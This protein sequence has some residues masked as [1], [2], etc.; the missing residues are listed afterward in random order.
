MREAVI[1]GLGIALR[2]IRDVG[3]EL[4]AGKLKVVLP[5]Y[6]ASERVAVHAIYPTRRFLPVKVRVFIDFL[7]T[8][9]G[10]VPYWDAGLD[11][12]LPDLAGNEP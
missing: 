1:S 11:A 9:Y 3:P 10:P 7:A 4:A 8:L 6:R 2:S 5:A 12:V